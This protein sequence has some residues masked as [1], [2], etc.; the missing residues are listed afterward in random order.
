MKFAFQGREADHLSSCARGDAL[1]LVS[2]AGP[3][4]FYTFRHLTSGESGLLPVSFV[5][6]LSPEEAAAEMVRPQAA[7]GTICRAKQ[8]SQVQG[9]G[10][11]DHLS[12]DAGDL[13]VLISRTQ[14]DRWTFWHVE[15]GKTG[16][17]DVRCVGEVKASEAV[18]DAAEAASAIKAVYQEEDESGTRGYLHGFTQKVDQLIAEIQVHESEASRE[19]DL[20]KFRD[21][22]DGVETALAQLAERVATWQQQHTQNV[23]RMEA[24]REKR[25]VLL[26]RDIQSLIDGKL[27]AEALLLLPVA[28]LVHVTTTAEKFIAAFGIY[29]QLQQDRDTRYVTKL[30]LSQHPAKAILKKVHAPSL[31]PSLSVELRAELQGFL[32]AEKQMVSSRRHDV[33]I[34]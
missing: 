12:Y 18:G 4:G 22:S 26:R 28:D 2:R 11:A 5:T 21:W 8:S 34:G 13:L 29:S 30:P 27:K 25:S 3:D 10:S 16:L 23:K 32:P 17:V 31:L 33:C 1:L 24:R 6:E 15:T 14:A 9:R 20:R 7:I 19:E